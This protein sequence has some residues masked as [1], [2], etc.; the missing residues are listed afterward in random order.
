MRSSTFILVNCTLSMPID[1]R[2]QSHILS[3]EIAHK[4]S[5]SCIDE[6]TDNGNTD[7]NMPILDRSAF[8]SM[9]IQFC[10]TFT[11]SKFPNRPTLHAAVWTAVIATH[12]TAH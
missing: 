4:E 8:A 6:N 9:S 3:D 12:W 7:D 2:S 11:A 5:Y 1:A 10:T